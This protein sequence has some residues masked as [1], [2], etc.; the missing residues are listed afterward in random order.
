[1]LFSD[2]G[3]DGE[4]IFKQRLEELEIE[5]VCAVG[6]GVVRIVVDFDEEAVNTRR[7]RSAREQRNVLGLTAADAVGCRGLLDRVGGVK[8][9]GRETAHDGERAEIDD[10]VVIAERRTALGEED[11]FVARGADFLE[12]VAHVPW[13]NELAFLNVDCTAG[14]AGCDEQIGLAAKECGNLEN[15]GGF[16]DGFAVGRL[17]DVSEDGKACIFGDFAEDAHALFEAGTAETFRAGAIGLV[18]AGLEDEG[19]CEVGGDALDCFSNGARMSFG[20]DDAGAGD[21]EKLT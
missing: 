10:E 20:L 8:D 9:D 3:V 21:Q 11:A 15:V 18:V 1:L 16:C 17:V 6:F 12:A 5:G 4:E 2:G 19:N 7:D 13:S 14:F